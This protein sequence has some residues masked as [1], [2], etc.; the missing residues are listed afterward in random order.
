[1]QEKEDLHELIDAA[2]GAYL[3]AKAAEKG[4]AVAKKTAKSAVAKTAARMQRADIIKRAKQTEVGS[5]ERKQAL[6][7]SKKLKQDLEKRI[8]SIKKQ[9]PKPK[10]KKKPLSRFKRQVKKSQSRLRKR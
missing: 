9:A 1:M 3:G 7:Q 6:K 5:Q 4:L 8:Q 10:K 2:I